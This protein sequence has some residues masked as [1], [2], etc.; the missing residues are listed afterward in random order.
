VGVSFHLLAEGATFH[1]FANIGTKARPPE[2]MLDKFFCF[3]MARMA[4]HGV[5]ME[6]AKKIMPGRRRDIGTG[7]IIQDRIDDFPV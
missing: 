3:E 4:C 7:F 6:P 1:I 2:V 5:V